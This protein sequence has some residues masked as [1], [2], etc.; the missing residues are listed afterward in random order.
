[1]AVNIPINLTG[2]TSKS[3]SGFL[4]KQ[5][6]LNLYPEAT[7]SG[8]VLKGFPG[9]VS[10]STGD[11]PCRGGFVHKNIM[12]QVSG[13]SLVTIDITGARTNRGTIPGTSRCI[14]SGNGDIIV[15]VTEGLAYQWDGAALTQITDIDLESPRS[16]ATLNSQTLYDG[17][18]GRFGVS[19]VG[20]PS[21]INS[22]N[23]ATAES[24]ADDIV[25]VFDYDQL[26]YLFNTDTTEPWWNSG[27]GN[28][29]FDPIEGGAIPVGLLALH[30]VASND[31]GIYFLGNDKN[32]H[33]IKG[34]SHENI[35]PI[36]LASELE[37]LETTEDAEGHTFSLHGQNFY[38]ITFRAARRTFCYNESV[39]VEN[40][41][42][43]LSSQNST[44][45]RYLAS[46][47]LYFNKKNYVTDFRD[48]NI[49]ELSVTAF[50]ENGENISRIRDTA[51]L[52][53]GLIGSPGKEITLNRFELLMETGT[54]NVAVENPAVSISFSDDG[55]RTFG[56]EFPAT[57]GQAGDFIWKVEWF[58]MGSFLRRIIR[59]SMSDAVFW[60]IHG[61]AA[62]LEVSI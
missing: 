40:G 58:D 39:G 18:G 4:S 37:A 46:A 55:G 31:S 62:D 33:F 50:D 53:G 47:H 7:A 10:F 52:H 59:V 26:A 43:E 49:Y 61:A 23:Y 21:S 28:P 36:H 12:Y 17:D 2:P 29:P 8:F 1:V 13:T 45:E 54:G 3:Q 9:L 57:V 19:D 30:S 15:I 20:V 56:T 16:C 48:G 60:C 41:W 25:R 32:V 24:N 38:Q 35:T 14:F 51:T 34:Q 5:R 22:L 42:F 44:N 11:G 6:T 27:Q